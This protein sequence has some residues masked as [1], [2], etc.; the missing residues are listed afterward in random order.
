[1]KF[2]ERYFRV[3]KKNQQFLILQVS[4][5]TT[6]TFVPLAYHVIEATNYKYSQLLLNAIWTLH[7]Y[8]LCMNAQ[9][10]MPLSWSGIYVYMGKVNLCQTEI[11]TQICRKYRTMWLVNI[12]IE[13]NLILGCEMGYVMHSIIYITYMYVHCVYHIM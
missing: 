2:P 10:E 4:K 6:T 5:S 3:P 1:M 11:P 13:Y 12:I 7:F 8:I 9:N